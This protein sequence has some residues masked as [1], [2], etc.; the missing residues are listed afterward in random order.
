LVGESIVGWYTPSP[1]LRTLYCKPE[2]KLMTP[3]FFA[4]SSNQAVDS[5]FDAML[6]ARIIV[7]NKI[8]NVGIFFSKRYQQSKFAILK[9]RKLDACSNN[10]LSLSTGYAKVS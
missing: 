10:V 3:A 4:F 2:G 9:M 6:L 1:L 8:K 5:G 7:S